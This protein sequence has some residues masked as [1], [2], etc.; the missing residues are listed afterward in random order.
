MC[1]LSTC[2]FYVPKAVLTRSST[3][4]SNCGRKV[5]IFHTLSRWPIPQV[6]TRRDILPSL[7][8]HH[9]FLHRRLDAYSVVT[10]Q[11][12]RRNMSG[13]INSSSGNM[14]VCLIGRGGYSPTRNPA[15]SC[16]SSISLNK[17][18][19]WKYPVYLWITIWLQQQK[20]NEMIAVAIY[21]NS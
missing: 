15:S 13:I 14:S 4:R 18:Q 21:D 2:P 11:H 7:T 1:R 10:Y 16:R 8:K 6:L 20:T 12:D 5:Q 3:T 9:F 19:T 17:I